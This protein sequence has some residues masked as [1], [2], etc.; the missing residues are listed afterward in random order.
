MKRNNKIIKKVI[1][2]IVV[3]IIICIIFRKPIEKNIKEDII[4]FKIWNINNKK[5][6]DW[7]GDEIQEK[8]NFQ[9]V[10]NVEEQNKIEFKHLNLGKIVDNK[11]LVKDKIAP[12]TKGSF[13]IIINSYI[14][15]LYQIKF[16]SLNKKP[17]NLT[18][19]REGSLNKYYQ[20]EE[21]EKELKG[22]MNKR[23]KK[24]KNKLGMAI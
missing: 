18:F 7:I 22:R 14:D 20:I 5:I 4:F 2:I 10:F 15:C 24:D 21:L 12:G 3:L 16:K 1:V 9:C 17:Q 19:Q 8:E 13:E 11:T 6:S 23:T